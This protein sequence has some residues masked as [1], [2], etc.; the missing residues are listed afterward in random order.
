MAVPCFYQVL[1]TTIAWLLRAVLDYRVLGTR[2]A[3]KRCLLGFGFCISLDSHCPLCIAL[4]ISSWDEGKIYNA[5]TAA[6]EA[7]VR[8]WNDPL[9]QFLVFL[10]IRHP[11]G[12]LVQ[13]H[14]LLAVDFQTAKI[15]TIREIHDEFPLVAGS[16]Y[17]VETE[18]C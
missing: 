14:R 17:V 4:A 12:Y 2:S 7:R 13:K 10:S 11:I 18:V 9:L 8:T 16:S 6:M 5:K 15:L 3:I 1:R